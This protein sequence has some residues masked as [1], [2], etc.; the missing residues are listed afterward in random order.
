MCDRKDRVTLKRESLF[1]RTKSASHRDAHGRR[2][3]FFASQN[4]SGIVK[5]NDMGVNGSI[6]L[7]KSAVFTCFYDRLVLTT[8]N[9]YGTLKKI[10]CINKIEQKKAGVCSETGW[11]NWISMNTISNWR[12]LISW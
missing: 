9:R 7:T 4:V 12:K 5:L 10:Y 2:R 11:R 3:S 1:Y 8:K 6:F